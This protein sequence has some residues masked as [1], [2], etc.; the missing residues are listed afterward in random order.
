[1]VLDDTGA[2]VDRA[3]RVVEHTLT[4]GTWTFVLDTWTDGSGTPLS[5][6][7]L[8]TVLECDSRDSS[9]G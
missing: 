3:H 4:P 7:Y 6:S 2:C 5:G 8:F 1:M 9:C